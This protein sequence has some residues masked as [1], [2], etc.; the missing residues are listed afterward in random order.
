MVPTGIWQVLQQLYGNLAEAQKEE[1]YSWCYDTLNE[2]WRLGVLQT[3][4]AV[5]NR[6]CRSRDATLDNSLCRAIALL[7]GRLHQGRLTLR[8][9]VLTGRQDEAVC[10]AAWVIHAAFDGTSGRLTE[11]IRCR[12]DRAYRILLFDGGERG[13][14]GPGGAGSIIVVGGMAS[15]PPAIIWMGSV[16]LAASATTNNVAK[17]KGLLFGL[18]KA[19]AYNLDGLHV[20][21]D[22]NLILGHMRRRKQPKARHLQDL[23]RQCRTIADRLNVATWQHHLRHFNKMADA[24]A[25]IAMDSKKSTQIIQADVKRLPHGGKPSRHALKGDLGHWIDMNGTAHVDK[26]RGEAG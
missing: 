17:Y 23:Y 10:R 15:N 22:S 5:W 21:G 14:P 26:V 11:E 20:V 13:N 7:R 24:L 4:Q 3:L 16:S 12:D 1:I 6:R 19:Q 18:R 25:N 9:F 2:H 8:E